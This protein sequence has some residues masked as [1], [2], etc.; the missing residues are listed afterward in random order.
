M[1][2]VKDRRTTVFLDLEA[3]AAEH[4]QAI[5]QAVD[6]GAYDAST[7]PL[8]GEV[9]DEVAADYVAAIKG[10]YA[11]EGGLNWEACASKYCLECTECLFT[12]T[13]NFREYLEQATRTFTTMLDR[14]LELVKVEAISGDANEESR[15]R[16]AEYSMLAYECANRIKILSM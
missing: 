6:S 1:S 16:I 14:Y 12:L 8:F 15:R 13:A 11:R 5:V 3:C 10:A 9:L 7:V 4:F 2:S